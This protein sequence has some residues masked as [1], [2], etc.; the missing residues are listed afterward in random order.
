MMLRRLF[1]SSALALTVAAGAMM[2]AMAADDHIINMQDVDIKAFIEN[3]GI[4]TG[5]TFVI[6]PRVNGKVNI[7]S[8]KPLNDNQV[9]AVFK[10][11]LRVHGYTVVRAANGEY[12][13]TLLQGSAQDAPFSE[14]GNGIYGQFATTI[15]RVPDGKAAEA[16][17]LIKPVMHSLSLIHI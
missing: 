11:V 13:V 2:P 5:R 12:R 17:R 6:D 3:V 16:A 15:L 7:V 4:V 10:E 14:S 9:F 8:E 1:V